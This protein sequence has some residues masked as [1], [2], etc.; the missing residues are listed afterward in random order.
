MLTPLETDAS[1]DGFDIQLNPIVS[2]QPYS[3]L[4]SEICY[5]HASTINSAWN[6]IFEGCIR[7]TEGGL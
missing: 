7:Q 6:V 1:R 5:K 4:A 2:L 3:L